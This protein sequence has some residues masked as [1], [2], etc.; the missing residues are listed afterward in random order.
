[1]SKQVPTIFLFHGNDSLASSKSLKAWEQ[2]FSQK[3]GDVSKYRIESDEY[4]DVAFGREIEQALTSQGL[5]STK[6]FCIVKRPTALEKGNARAYSTKLVEQLTKLV[7]SSD[8]DCTVVVWED[9]A[10][11]D[12]HTISKWFT[13][14]EQRGVAKRMLH[15]VLHT[16]E[17]VRQ[18]QAQLAQH[19]LA[20]SQAGAQHLYQSL[21]QREK[22]QRLLAQLRSQESLAKDMRSWWVQQLVEL[23]IIHLHAPSIVEAADIA[24]VTEELQPQV[25]I[26]EVANAVTG[27]SLRTALQVLD[28]WEAASA[29]DSQYFALM[30]VLRKQAGPNKRLLKLLAEAELLSKNGVLPLPLL[31]HMLTRRLFAQQ[32][33]ILPPRLV[34]L[35]KLPTP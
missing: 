34:W 30:S 8:T 23:L 6:R 9:K 31:L 22:E 13:E 25:S 1:M 7:A 10:L 16:R 3:H 2:L 29:E 15:T 20:L 19:N 17:L 26:F 24:R 35:S 18:V 28:Q 32:N 27:S 14:H 21:I 33:E 4:D 5:F 12:T 11:S